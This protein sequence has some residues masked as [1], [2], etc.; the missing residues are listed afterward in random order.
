[1]IS[2]QFL[3]PFVPLTLQLVVK[4]RET[5]R[6]HYHFVFHHLVGLLGELIHSGQPLPCR[7][8]KPCAG[9]PLWDVLDWESEKKK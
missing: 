4:K 6:E 5:K 3:Q 9:E 8:L 1:M 2:A 7:L